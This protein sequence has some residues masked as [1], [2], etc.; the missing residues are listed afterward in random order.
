M[1]RFGLG[2]RSRITVAFALGGLLVAFLLAAITLTTTRQVLLADREEIAEELALSN[3]SNVQRQLG[4]DLDPGAV[5]GVVDSLSTATGSRPLLIIDNANF[6][7]DA[8]AFSLDD[9]PVDLQTL[10]FEGN[11]G[12]IRSVVQ[13]SPAIVYGVPIRGFDL[14][15]IHI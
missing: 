14:S 8:T 9:V 6:S 15:L 10:T 13:D 7:R 3:A 5:Q 1:S 11:A 12:R 2:L 4:G